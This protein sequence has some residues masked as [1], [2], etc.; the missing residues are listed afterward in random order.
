VA[1]SAAGALAGPVGAWTSARHRQHV[2]AFPWL[3]APHVGQM[4]S[5]MLMDEVSVV[6]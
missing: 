1:G 3:I 6:R 5:C 4:T 2:S